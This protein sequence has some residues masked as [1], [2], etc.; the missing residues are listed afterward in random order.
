MISDED[1]NVFI[2][3][4]I[5][6]LAHLYMYGVYT[7]THDSTRDYVVWSLVCMYMCILKTTTVKTFTCTLFLYIFMISH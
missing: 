2:A 1:I 5:T 7:Y 6:I 4:C 3:E